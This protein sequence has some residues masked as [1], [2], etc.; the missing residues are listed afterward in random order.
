MKSLGA[1]L[2]LIALLSA[3]KP[4]GAASVY[5]GTLAADQPFTLNVDNAASP[6]G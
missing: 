3:A 4:A 6:A 5:M 2:L 1:S